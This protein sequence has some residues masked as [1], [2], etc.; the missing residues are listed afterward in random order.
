YLRIDGV[1]DLDGE[2][3]LL[4]PIGSV[5]DYAGTGT[6]H[7]DQQ[8]TSN[9]YNY[10]Y[11]G[12]PV[13]TDGNTYQ[14][15][16]LHDGANPVNWTTNN[17]ATGSTN[18]VTLSSRWLYLYENHPAGDYASW[19]DIN[20]T[21]PVSVGLGFTMKGSGVGD[22]INDVQNYT[23]VGKPNNGTITSPVTGG[24]EALVGNPYPSALDADLFIADNSS[25]ITGPLYFWEHSR[26]NA[27]HITV[28]YEGGYAAYS[29]SGGV[30]ATTP[31]AG[32]GGV[33]LVGKIPR[34]YVPVGQGFYV[35]GDADGG[36]ITFNNSQRAFV[37][38]A[39][40]NSIFL[41]TDDAPETVDLIKR[42]RLNFTSP[43][44]AI[45]PL[46]L[47]FTPNNE[48]TDGFDYG[49]DAKN[50]DVFPSD[51]S[52]VIDN[53]NYVIQG[54][55]DFNVDNMYPVN[56]SLGTSGTIEIALTDLENFDEDID[57]YVYDALLGDYARI[58]TV[59]YQM[60]LDAG[61]HANRYFIAFK[62]DA[63]LNTVDEEFS[64]VLVNY[65]NATNEVYINV[66]TSVDIKQVYLVNMLGQTVKSWN[67]TNA[68]LAHECRLPVKNVSEGNYIIKVRTSDNKLINKKV[69]IM[70]N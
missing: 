60:A 30:A 53:E 15:N 45:R 57:V 5:V 11:W 70:Q 12:S 42:I 32:L 29:L 22:P 44:G 3:Q 18:P 68:P 64:N 27:S 10:N 51:M 47:A 65:L 46:L 61:N 7:R 31:P 6:L 41:R 24:N 59:N 19:N 26:T 62:E 36:T 38:E 49:Y 50:S 16:A 21:Y 20:E 52:F 66:P 43:E 48:A 63:T 56:I 37:K 17:D 34:R 9:L 28:D 14:I 1:L 55:G 69:I 35:T 58:N 4:Q 67:A 54:V 23:F 8:G 2:S 13:S 25:S 39:S 40:G 33:G